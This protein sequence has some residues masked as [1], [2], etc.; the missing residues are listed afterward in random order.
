[1]ITLATLLASCASTPKG[2]VVVNCVSDPLTKSLQCVDRQGL[3]FIVPW[4]QSANFVCRPPEDDQ[5]LNEKA[6]Q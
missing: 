4:E 1:M 3:D 6:H 2:V 5:L